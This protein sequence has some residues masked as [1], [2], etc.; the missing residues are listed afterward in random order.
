MA[1]AP[2]PIF[3]VN[4]YTPHPIPFPHKLLVCPKSLGLTYLTIINSVNSHLLDI[5]KGW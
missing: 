5:L 4:Y 2:C 3:P 1:V